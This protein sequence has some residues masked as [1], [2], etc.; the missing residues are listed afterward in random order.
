M[1]KTNLAKKQ[2]F[3]IISLKQNFPSLIFSIC[4][5]FIMLLIVF[6]PAIFSESTISGIKLFFNSVLPGLL[7][8]MF[9]TKL[10]TE[11]GLVFKISKHFSKGSQ[12]LFGTPGV[13]IYCFFMSIFSG[14]P[15]GAKIICDLYKQGQISSED[16]KRMSIFC[17]TSGPIFVIGAVGVGMFSSF[18]LGVIIYISH[19][20]SSLICGIGYNLIFK[21]KNQTQTDI[22]FVSKTDENIITK[23]LS[24]TINSLFLVGGFITIFYLL[25]EVFEILGIITFLTKILSKILPF[26]DASDISGF[27][28]GLIEV[29]H[30]IKELSLSLSPNIALICGLISFSGVSI[31][32]QSMSF[33]KEAKIK[34]HTFIFSKCVQMLLSIIFCKLVLIIW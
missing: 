18:K 25:T 26:L 8:F 29:T 2:K 23:C 9:L 5:I 32:M 10:L 22:V 16:A 20:L 4:V 12:K 30:G 3:F 19:I 31:I 21:S 33:L 24:D 15:I 17:T 7:P 1:T 11:L 13:S 27:L 14:Y 28:Y 6:N 34:T